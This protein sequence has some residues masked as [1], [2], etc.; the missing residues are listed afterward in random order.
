MRRSPSTEQTNGT[1]RAPRGRGG[2]QLRPDAFA[3]RSAATKAPKTAEVPK[4]PEP[5]RP[6]APR[7]NLA[8]VLSRRLAP[9]VIGVRE[10]TEETFGRAKRFQRRVRARVEDNIAQTRGRIVQLLAKP[11]DTLTEL[12]EAADGRTISNR[13]ESMAELDRDEIQL[14]RD[15]AVSEFRRH[16]AG[17]TIVEAK[18]RSPDPAFI[19]S[20]WAC[21]LRMHDGGRRQIVGLLL[22]GDPIGLRGA[23]EPEA[24]TT[25]GALTEVHAISAQRLLA[26]VERSNRYSNLERAIQRADAQDKEFLTNQIARLGGMS[27]SDRFADLMHELKWRLRQ[28]GLADASMFP[29][30]LDQRDLMAT[31]NLSRGELD[32]AMRRLRRRE[33][34]R[35]RK[36]G[37]RLIERGNRTEIVGGFRPPS[38]SRNADSRPLPRIIAD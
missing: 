22:P 29:M 11:R 38:G 8:K 27:T 4:P 30:P 12:A 19:A 35:V 9:A 1:A 14:V 3:K 7:P 10:G 18:E 6:A 25:I 32:S 26:Q 36:Q 16:Q 17:A 24:T 23:A 15:F 20:G 33:G 31:L 37:A 5:T 21:R 2:P 34:F 28:T 13:I